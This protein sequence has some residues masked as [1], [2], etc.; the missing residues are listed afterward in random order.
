ME[1]PPRPPAKFSSPKIWLHSIP[2][3]FHPSY[4][5]LN[6]HLNHLSLMHNV[7]DLDL[8]FHDLHRPQQNRRDLEIIQFPRRLSESSAVRLAWQDKSTCE[9]FL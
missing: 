8:V 7:S 5:L 3:N 6:Q 4:T 9:Y 2:P 1:R